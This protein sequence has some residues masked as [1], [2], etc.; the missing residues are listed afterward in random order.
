MC[1]LAGRA[2]SL[3]RVHPYPVLVALT[4]L[5]AGE[6]WLAHARLLPVRIEWMQ[7]WLFF[8]SVVAW[9]GMTYLIG[10]TT[11]LAWTLPRYAIPIL[12]VGP[13]VIFGGALDSID[14]F[15]FLSTQVFNVVDDAYEG[16]EHY[17]RR[18]MEAVDFL[19]WLA[20]SALIALTT[21]SVR[22]TRSYAALVIYP[23]MTL[24]LI[25]LLSLQNI[26]FMFNPIE[27]IGE[28]NANLIL[29]LVIAE[30]AGALLLVLPLLTAFSLLRTV[31]VQRRR[32][33]WMYIQIALLSL[34]F[35]ATMLVLAALTVVIALVHP[36]W[37]MGTVLAVPLTVLLCT[38]RRRLRVIVVTATGLWVLTVIMGWYWTTAISDGLDQLESRDR[39]AAGRML[40][41]GCDASFNREALRV[42][43][44]D[45]GLRLQHYILWRLPVPCRQQY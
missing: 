22:L 13:P 2:I 33:L 4:I 44:D 40:R 18:Q 9:S 32:N 5:I 37:V 6:M 24:A 28:D 42:V 10:V 20:G 12:L 7:G 26:P 36:W 16:F 31:F 29:M 34:A 8:L 17:Y 23:L 19:F 27:R 45:E 38:I 14:A 30:I 35:T 15:G 39:T 11:P 1:D 21:I 25:F 41:E 3:V 43:R